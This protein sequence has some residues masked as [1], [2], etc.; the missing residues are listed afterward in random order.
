MFTSILRWVI[1]ESREK[2]F[3]HPILA[4]Q[5]FLETKPH[6]KLDHRTL[7]VLDL[8]CNMEVYDY[9]YNTLTDN[10]CND[11]S[12]LHSVDV[13]FGRNSDIHELVITYWTS[14]KPYTLK[15][16]TRMVSTP[17]DISTMLERGY[18]ITQ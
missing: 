10:G 14:I 12:L 5:K 13:V 1:Q 16:K 8:H 15:Y 3:T 17:T 11:V 2:K 18:G 4:M 6:C 9:A 7:R